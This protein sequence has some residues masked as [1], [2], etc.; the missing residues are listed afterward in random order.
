M[1]KEIFHQVETVYD[2]D[3]VIYRVSGD[4]EKKQLRFSFKCNAF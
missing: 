3:N 2:T 4:E 1:E